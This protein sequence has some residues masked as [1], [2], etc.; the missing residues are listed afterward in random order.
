MQIQSN[1]LL[2]HYRVSNSVTAMFVNTEIFYQKLII[3]ENKNDTI[4]I[5]VYDILKI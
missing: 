1:L 2:C 3:V 5:M 4:V